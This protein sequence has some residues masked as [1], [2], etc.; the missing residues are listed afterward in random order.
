MTL[1]LAAAL[2]AAASAFA[3]PQ[4]VPDVLLSRQLLAREHL[5]VGDVVELSGRPDS[6][7]RTFRIAGSYEPVPDPMRFAQERLEARLHLSD[8]Q[9]L[10]AGKGSGADAVSNINIKLAAGVSAQTFSEELSRRMPG[11][12]VKPTAAPDERTATFTVVERFHLAIAIVTVV[13]SGVFLLALMVMLV[14]ERRETVATL[15]LM[16]LTRGRILAQVL[17]EGTGIALAG[18]AFGIGLA[19]ASQRLFNQL[20]QWRY[21]TSLVFLRVT[22]GIIAESLGMAIPIGVMASAIAAWTILRRGAL[23]LVRR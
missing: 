16:G 15:R 19:L 14:D 13:G 1:P 12:V 8:L 5:R 3:A 18:A 17:I 21:D 2:V 10:A 9:E 4:A 7:T 22:P 20:F 11:L 6:E 23:A